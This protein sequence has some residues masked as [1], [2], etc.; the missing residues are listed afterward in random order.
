M[1][2]ETSMG[3]LQAIVEANRTDVKAITGGGGCQAYFNLMNEEQYQNIWVCSATYLPNMIINCVENAAAIL[4]GETV[5][6]E[7]VLESSIV[8]RENVQDFLNAD[9]PY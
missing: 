4:N 9:S 7:I 5:E 8:D 2:D 3:A 1:D 6:H